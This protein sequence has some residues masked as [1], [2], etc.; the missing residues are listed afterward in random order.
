M[1]DA[2]AAGEEAAAKEASKTAQE[3]VVAAAAE[4]DRGLLCQST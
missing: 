1:A 4:V 3:G 2:D